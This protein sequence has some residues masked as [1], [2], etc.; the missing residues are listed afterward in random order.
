MLRFT[1]HE[2]V[3]CKYTN[4]AAIRHM[5]P[6]SGE[7][8]C[9]SQTDMS[10][11]INLWVMDG[12]TMNDPLEG[13][14]LFD[15][16]NEHSVQRAGC[17]C[18]LHNIAQMVLR[19]N[20]AGYD[21][22]FISSFSA[23]QD[24]LQLWRMYGGDGLGICLVFSPPSNMFY[25]V[26]YGEEPGIQVLDELA[27]VIKPIIEHNSLD[28]VQAAYHMISPLR[29]LFKAAG[30][31]SDNE[32]RLIIVPNNLSGVCMNSSATDAKNANRLY[33]V[34]DNFFYSCRSNQDKIIVGPQAGLLEAT[35]GE[36]AFI[37]EIQ[38]RLYKNGLADI[39]VLRSKHILRY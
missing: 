13:R 11:G 16:S 2:T 1:E 23:S 24:N 7:S 20:P 19:S 8:S 10:R 4:F 25:E 9:T 32:Y 15:L 27:W 26:K 5:L 30:H 17:L 6:A 12:E 28:L 35:M 36:Q 14:Y 21:S 22:I 34:L 33:I 38:W 3:L 37:K 31:E 18:E 29:F 39:P